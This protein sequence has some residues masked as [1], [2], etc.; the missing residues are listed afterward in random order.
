MTDQTYVPNPADPEQTQPA[1]ERGMNRRNVAD[2]IAEWRAA[3][4]NNDDGELAS[5][6]N[7]YIATQVTPGEIQ[8]AKGR[9]AQ[10]A[11][12]APYEKWML[13]FG[14]HAREPLFFEGT[15]A[16]RTAKE[17]HR[18]LCDSW[19]CE[20]FL[21]AAD[22]PADGALREIKLKLY[23]LCNAVIEG[24]LVPKNGNGEWWIEYATAL[25]ALAAQRDK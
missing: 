14:D 13:V 3:S 16:R 22:L 25:R 18:K 17:T 23:S 7:Y 11:D 19:T 2:V 10:P 9:A 24:D 6:I 1:G 15:D 21:S 4:V 8:W 12:G 5:R 20:L